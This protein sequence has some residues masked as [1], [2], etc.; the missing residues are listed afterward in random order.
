MV[1]ICGI[2]SRVAYLNAVES[3]W[4]TAVKSNHAL[5]RLH[6]FDARRTLPE[7]L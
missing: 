7:I 2:N 6:V 5:E 1:I 3:G 4:I